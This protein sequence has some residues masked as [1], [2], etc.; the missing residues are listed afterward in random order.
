[1]VNVSAMTETERNGFAM[2]ANSP[3]SNHFPGVSVEGAKSKDEALDMA[4]G[5]FT[6]A[7]AALFSELPEDPTG[8]VDGPCRIGYPEQKGLYRTDSG[9]TLST[10]GIDYEI[11][12]TS[13]AFEVWDD[14]ISTGHCVPLGVHVKD[15]GK[16]IRTFS[17]IGGAEIDQLTGNGGTSKDELGHFLDMRTGHTGKDG[18]EFALYTIRLICLNGMTS[19]TKNAYFSIRHTKNARERLQAANTAI[20]RI[21]EAAQVEGQALARMASTPMSTWSYRQFAEGLLNYSRGELN[22]DSTQNARTRRD[23]DLGTLMANF[24]SGVGNYGAS[25]YD[26]YNSITQWL[27]PDRDSFTDPLKFERK[28][29]SQSS[30]A[31][32]RLKGDAIRLLTQPA[33]RAS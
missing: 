11:I 24:V 18:I 19:R 4:R 10:V 27:T 5:N 30:G 22:N 14:L 26:A 33:A 8:M 15:G 28:W 16:S 7:E 23:N 25:Q 31:A 29:E 6:V 13:E 21:H 9:A 2:G 12:Q 32:N 17:R 1:M 20:K 3:Y